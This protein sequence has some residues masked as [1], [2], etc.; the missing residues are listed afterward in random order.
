MSIPFTD[1]LDTMFTMNELDDLLTNEE[2]AILERM[3][4]GSV[5]IMEFSVELLENLREALVKMDSRSAGYTFDVHLARAYTAYNLRE[6]A[7]KLEPAFSPRSWQC[8]LSE[9]RSMSSAAVEDVKRL[10]GINVQERP[11]EKRKVKGK[12][13][14]PT[15][16]SARLRNALKA[17]DTDDVENYSGF[18]E[19]SPTL[20]YLLDANKK[21]ALKITVAEKSRLPFTLEEPHST[22]EHGTFGSEVTVLTLAWQI[23]QEKQDNANS[24]W[25]DEDDYDEDD[26]DDEELT[27][28]TKPSPSKQEYL[29]EKAADSIFS[30]WELARC[31]RLAVFDEERKNILSD[32]DGDADNV[33][34][35]YGMLRDIAEH[36]LTR[37]MATYW[38]T[39][40]DFALTEHD[41]EAAVYVLTVESFDVVVRPD[42]VT[43]NQPNQFG[44]TSFCHKVSSVVGV[45]TRLDIALRYFDTLSSARISEMLA[46]I[47]FAYDA[48]GPTGQVFRTNDTDVCT[49]ERPDCPE[50]FYVADPGHLEQ[51]N[52]EDADH[53]FSEFL[54]DEI[55]NVRG[56]DFSQTADHNFDL[57]LAPGCAMHLVAVGSQTVE[58]PFMQLVAEAESAKAF[59]VS[60][61]KSE[62]D[63]ATLRNKGMVVTETPDITTLEFRYEG[64]SF[65]VHVYR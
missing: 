40:F 36:P 2:F 9:G 28:K 54:R 11:L 35:L 1:Y 19:V 3:R 52:S 64:S 7:Q 33:S 6:H 31:P 8:W 26:E 24:E 20:F 42:S 18:K 57:I 38:P 61:S 29:E 16:P 12:P 10:V 17:T 50:L 34:S 53:Q 32:A 43:V 55:H 60:L 27:T 13:V 65:L 5:S 25:P 30:R 22:T 58:R 15:E 39:S 41:E 51:V 4:K 63:L 48:G 37:I 14:V 21:D 47:G 49:V 46:E 44:K 62:I 45:R 56:V 23:L 59:Y